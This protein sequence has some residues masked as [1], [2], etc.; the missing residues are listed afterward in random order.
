MLVCALNCPVCAN[1]HTHPISKI[2]EFNHFLAQGSPESDI[3]RTVGHSAR[4]LTAT[5]LYMVEAVE[6]PFFD[7]KKR[8]SKNLLVRFSFFVLGCRSYTA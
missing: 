4:V 2:S 3:S 5:E 6:N 8:P 1:G 7:V